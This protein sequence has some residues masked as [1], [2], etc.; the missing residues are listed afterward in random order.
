MKKKRAL[1]TLIQDYQNLRIQ[2]FA[3]V[4]FNNKNKNKAKHQIKRSRGYCGQAINNRNFP[5][6]LRK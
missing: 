6:I 4:R 1:I 5:K 3:K 2:V